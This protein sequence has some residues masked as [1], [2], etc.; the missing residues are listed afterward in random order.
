M[1]GALALLPAPL[2]IHPNHDPRF[3]AFFAASSSAASCTSLS[4]RGFDP[5]ITALLV[6][7]R[8]P[9]DV[10][11]RGGDDGFEST[12]AASEDESP[13]LLP[14][15]GCLFEMTELRCEAEGLESL[16]SR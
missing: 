4:G 16:L 8:S 10:V 6:L 2:L 1:L 11:L 12:G 3:V 13:P 5:I 7:S 14:S 9:E 15:A